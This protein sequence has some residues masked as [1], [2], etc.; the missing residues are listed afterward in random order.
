MQTIN[1][2][3]IN[4]VTIDSASNGILDN[5]ILKFKE[6]EYLKIENSSSRKSSKR[7]EEN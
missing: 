4:S 6:N 2:V 1:R 5:L 3:L 7:E